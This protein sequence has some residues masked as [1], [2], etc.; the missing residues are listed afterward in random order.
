MEFVG[1]AI[2]ARDEV[3]KR[4]IYAWLMATK[5]TP[6]NCPDSLLIRTSLVRI[7]LPEPRFTRRPTG[8]VFYWGSNTCVRF[9]NFQIKIVIF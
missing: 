9:D 3:Q 8:T 2:G 4:R 7:Q 1:A 5:M 6:R